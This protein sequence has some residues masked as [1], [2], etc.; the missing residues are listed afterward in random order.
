MQVVYARCAG[1]DIHKK[2]VVACRVVPGPNGQPSKEIR[3]FSTMTPE[4]LALRDWL[5][6]GGCTHVAMESTG[7]YWQPLFNLFEGHFELLLVN[8]QHVQQVPGRKSDVRD[9]EWLADLLRHGL[10]RGSFVPERDMRELRELTRYRTALVQERAA[11]VN[12]LQKTREGANIKLAAVAADITGKSARDMLAA[13]VGGETDPAV[14]A[15]LA[16]GRL[17]EKLPQ[18]QQAL[19][20]EFR[21]HQQF[22]VAQQLAHI[23]G[24]EALID[25]VSAEV[26]ARLAPFEPLLELL[27]T[28]PG[29]GR[30][31]AEVLA[32]EVGF[33]LERFP[34]AGHLVSWA[35]LCPGQEES[36]GKVKSRRIRKG[37][38]WLRSALVE[39]A[40]AASRTKNTYAAAQY[41]RL[42]AR[43]GT[44]RAAI[45]VAHSLLVAYY[46]ILKQGVPYAELGAD[47]FE[48]RDRESVVRRAVRRLEALGY[49][50]DLKEL[51]AAA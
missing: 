12:R 39:A 24:L 1:L 29:V 32:A 17:R 20:G 18:L 46:H 51:P 6:A 10:L 15:E 14:L 4:L 50:V 41:R 2:T 7:V 42:A 19:Q 31:L 9:C 27:E 30:R 44:R 40:R 11:A 43:R 35:A 16:R 21:A 33:V 26:A 49:A 25:T 22:L 38:P 45:A 47:Y 8:A 5:A 23:D 28:I 37:N 36:G 13:L 34:S 3:T 48:R